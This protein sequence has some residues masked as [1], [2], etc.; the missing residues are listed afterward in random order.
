[1]PDYALTLAAEQDL[2]EI[3]AYTFVEFGES[4]ADTYFESLEDCL[5]RLATNPRLGRSV[6]DLRRGYRRFIHQRHSIY[7]RRTRT[8]ILV[9]RILGPGRLADTILP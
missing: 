9:V 8:G 3:Y 1:M 5:T 7:Y 6:A 4:Q 2:T